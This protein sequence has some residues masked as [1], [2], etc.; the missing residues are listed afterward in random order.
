MLEKTSNEVVC[1]WVENVILGHIL[2]CTVTIIKKKYNVKL[3]LKEHAS[4][5]VS[6]RSSKYHN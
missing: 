6:F 4:D 2:T 1:R 5:L 3:L